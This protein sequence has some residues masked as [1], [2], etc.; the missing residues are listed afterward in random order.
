MSGRARPERTFPR[1]IV[2]AGSHVAAQ[3]SSSIAPADALQVLFLSRVMQSDAEGGAQAQWNTTPS[4]TRALPAAVRLAVTWAVSVGGLRV[5][6]S[7]CP[8]PAAASLRQAT[9]D[10][11][12]VEYRVVARSVR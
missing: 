9:L 6:P 11:C 2:P 10:G 5:W 4:A 3:T 12:L 8:Y 1:L 7:I